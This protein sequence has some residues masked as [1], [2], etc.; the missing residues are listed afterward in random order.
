MISNHIQKAHTDSFDFIFKSQNP[1]AKVFVDWLKE[2]YDLSVSNAI[3]SGAST[4]DVLRE[5]AAANTL[6]QILNRI[7]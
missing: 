2:S 6:K 1:H 5:A 4:E 7:T 3:A